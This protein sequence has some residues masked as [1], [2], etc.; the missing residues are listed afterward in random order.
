MVQLPVV[1]VRTQQMITAVALR[2][3]IPKQQLRQRIREDWR[4]RIPVVITAELL[5]TPSSSRAVSNVVRLLS[6]AH[7][8]FL[9][10][11]TTVVGF[12]DDL[13]HQ[14]MWARGRLLENHNAQDV[15]ASI[16]EANVRSF[17]RS[18][19]AST[20]NA[21][22]N[23]PGLRPHVAPFAVVCNIQQPTM[24]RWRKL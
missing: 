2:R 22:G 8:A 9:S 18:R 15:K 24:L 16:V 7:L 12:K 1:Q 21:I 4:G 23:I 17:R 13:P 20:W 5:H 11:H 10:H 19:T 6:I 3:T 14:A